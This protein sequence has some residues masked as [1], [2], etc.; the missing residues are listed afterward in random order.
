MKSSKYLIVF[1]S[2]KTCPPCKKLLK[3]WEPLVEKYKHKINFKYVIYSNDSKYIFERLNIK[4][5]PYICVFK[6]S[7]N[8][9]DKNFKYMDEKYLKMRIDKKISE[10]LEDHIISL[11]D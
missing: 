7:S 8:D 10:T 9:D 11:I 6:K 4:S 1:F 3:H 2:G 5:V